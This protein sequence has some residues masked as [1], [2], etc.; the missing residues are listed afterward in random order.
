M[1]RATKFYPRGSDTRGAQWFRRHAWINHAA[2]IS[3]TNIVCA[4]AGGP[5]VG[6]VTLS[7]GQIERGALP[8]PQQRSKPDPIP[9]T[10]L[11]QLAVHKD[12]QGQGYARSLLVFALRAAFRASQ[13][14]GS[15]GVFTRPL[16]ESAW[17]LRPL[18]FPT[19]AFRSAPDHNRPY[20]RSG[21]KRVWV[22][23]LRLS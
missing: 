8:K 20:G 13:E 4:G 2:G 7:A 18:G 23:Q 11:G 21:A 1:F 17:C 22:R 14:I 5:I 19:S 16:G 6:Y 9:A 3:R 12:C 10:L 15:F